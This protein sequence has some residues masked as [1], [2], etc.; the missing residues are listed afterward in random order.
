MNRG[1]EQET[2]TPRPSVVRVREGRQTGTDG[3]RWAGRV[4]RAGQQ[5][6]EGTVTGGETAHPLTCCAIDQARPWSRL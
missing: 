4:G 5:R 3:F 2:R 6:A 1:R